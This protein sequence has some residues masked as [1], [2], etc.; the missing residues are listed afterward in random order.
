MP[1]DLVYIMDESIK[2]VWAYMLEEGRITDGIWSYYGGLGDVKRDYKDYGAPE[3]ALRKK[4]KEFGIDWN[5]TMSPKSSHES[6]FNGTFADSDKVEVLL[7]TLILKD[8]SEYIIGI[9]NADTHFSSYLKVLSRLAADKQRVK[10][11][12]GE[13]IDEKTKHVCGLQGYNGMID[14]P[15]PACELKK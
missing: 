4:V 10:D 12:L 7:G 1:K 8:G 11:I 2:F 9:S 13:D 5:K 14:P 3:I 6:K 15:C